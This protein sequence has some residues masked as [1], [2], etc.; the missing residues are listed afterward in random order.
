M[1]IYSVRH[2]L[3]LFCWM[4]FSEKT[5][6]QLVLLGALLF[7]T[8]CAAGILRE[9]S[10]SQDPSLEE[11][12]AFYQ[13]EREAIPPLKGLM[14]VTI[15]DTIEKGFWARWRSR[16]G[17]IEINGFEL[18]GGTLFN[19][20]MK[21]SEL[22]LVSSENNFTGSREGFEQYLKAHHSEIQMEWVTLLDWIAR[23]G[24]PDLSMSHQ[25]I[26]SK[27]DDQFILD[28][29]DSDDHL[30]HRVLI[31]RARL[32]VKQALFFNKEGLMLVRMMF[33]DYRPIRQ[34]FFPFFIK[35]EAHPRQMEIVFK[36]LKVLAE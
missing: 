25:P 34:A 21:G 16:D 19:L 33:D 23:A 28:F 4:I 11:L 5:S 10:P 1:T 35:I 30:T 8:G 22:T 27:E 32:R 2:S 18:L 9:A 15:T 12:L 20:K 24:L 13:R 7:F 3:S 26:L 36:A 17:A 6:R 29:F 14:K 31:E